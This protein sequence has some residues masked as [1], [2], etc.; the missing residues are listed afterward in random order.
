MI[1]QRTDR[2]VVGARFKMRERGIVQFPDLARKTGTV[3]ETN[4]RSPGIAV[5]FDLRK[6]TGCAWYGAGVW[7]RLPAPSRTARV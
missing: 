5:L 7:S 4:M 3:V 6:V 2:F 1:T